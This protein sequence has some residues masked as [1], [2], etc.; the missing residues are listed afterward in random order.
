MNMN[1]ELSKLETSVLKNGI[2]GL[3]HYSVGEVEKP[4]ISDSLTVLSCVFQ[5]DFV[6]NLLHHFWN[7]KSDICP[8][9]AELQEKQEVLFS[10]FIDKVADKF[11]R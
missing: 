5:S 8:L 7:S 9:N 4:D 2:D 6:K 10:E 3:V 11:N 1:N